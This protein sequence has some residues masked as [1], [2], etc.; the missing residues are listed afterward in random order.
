MRLTALLLCLVS[1]TSVVMAEEQRAAFDFGLKPFAKGFNDPVALESTP[2]EPKKLFV[3]ERAGMVRVLEDGKLARHDLLDIEAILSPQD[4][5]GLSS[6][7][8]PAD[9]AKSSAFYVSYTDKQGDT[10]IGRFPSK[11]SDTAD[12]ED[13]MV[14]LKVVQ[15][16]PHTHRSYIA[17]G[18]DTYLYISLGDSPRKRGVSSLAQNPKS[19]FGKVLRIDLSDPQRYRIPNDNPVADGSAGA[20]EVWALGFQQPTHLS[21]DPPTKRLFLVD[22]GREVQEIDIVE[23]GKNYGWGILEGGDCKGA[24]CAPSAST[25]PLY[26]Y[27]GSAVGGFVYNGDTHQSLKGAYIFADAPS[28]TLYKLSYQGGEWRSAALAQ[29]QSPITA[30]N[31][32]PDG[33]IYVATNDGT[34]AILEPQKSPN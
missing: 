9:Y 22:S 6:I 31:Q 33:Q 25:P 10:I 24:K 14:A 3:V 4:N 11:R 18:P 20:P 15:P 8:F 17:F 28:R 34:I 21:F 23:R 7:A 30:L 26:T 29:A 13:L 5:P 19:L 1:W 27:K 2:S 16:S 12:E 32:A